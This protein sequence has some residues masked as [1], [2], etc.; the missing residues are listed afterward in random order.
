MESKQFEPDQAWWIKTVGFPDDV[1][2]IIL[3][4]S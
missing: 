1:S 2:E 4:K 3:R